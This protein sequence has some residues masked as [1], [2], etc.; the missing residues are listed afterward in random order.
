MTFT[1][2]PRRRFLQLIVVSAAGLGL[3]ACGGDD[4]D[5]DDRNDNGGE[6]IVVAPEF[7]PQSVCSG[8][9]RPDSVILWTRLY[10][11]ALA[12]SDATLRLQLALDEAFDEQVL[13][14]E[15]LPVRTAHDHCLKLKVVDLQPGTFYYY[16]FL[17]E[18]DGMLLST[19]TGRTRTA[20]APD[21]DV[22]VRF[23]VLNCQD[24]I[25]RY[26]NTLLHLLEQDPEPDFLVHVGDYIYETTG[27]PSFQGG[28]AGRTIAFSD[29]DGAIALG[30]GD[31]VFYAASSLGNYREIYQAYRADPVMQRLNERF[32]LIAIW[33]DHE[34]SDDCW[35]ATATFFDGLRDEADPARRLRA[36]QVYFEYMPVDYPTQPGTGV[37]EAD[38]SQLYPNT[39]LYRDLQ[40]GRHLHL[41]LTDYRSFR[42]DHLIPEDAFPGRILMDRAALVA[43]FEIQSPGNGEA[44][45]QQQAA[46]FNAYLDMG[47]E[48][49]SA[50]AQALVPLLAVIYVQAGLPEA[51]AGAKA[52]VDLG[53]LVAVVVLNSLIAQYNQLVDAGQLPGPALAPV[54]ADTEAGLDRGLSVALMGKSAFF[55]DFGSRY[56]VVKPSYELYRAYA[57]ATDL[58]SENAYGEVQ[59]GW[60]Q[61][62]IGNSSATFL[63]LASSV[64]STPLI[65]DF[66]G[67]A[68]FPP[69]F[70]TS[71]LINVD[72][73]D[74]FPNFRAA[75]LNLLRTRGNGFLFAGDIHAGFVTDHG[76]VA[77]FTA[78]A[79]SSGS[80][81][82]FVA[83]AAAGFEGLLGPDAF[84]R[85][86]ELVV[87]NLDATLQ[88][89]FPGIL[90]ART[91]MHGWPLI[92]VDGEK[93]TA[94][95]HLVDDEVVF[96]SY[97]DD[98]QA[99]AALIT[100]RRFEFTVGS[101]T[102]REI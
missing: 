59:L 101:N 62:R 9:P 95:Y 74:G 45:Y 68:S 54:D 18:M 72:H 13:E 17:F 102:L 15:G 98:P 11:P 32:P 57:S 67:E 41:L 87:E 97:Y 49:W 8:D 51:E 31:T 85:F 58:A 14:I 2:L 43:T 82:S 86:Q 35:Q 78:P 33:D 77:D 7:F 38:N 46:A 36:E 20:P 25:G 61:E 63:A 44:I 16:R 70:R 56:G 21:A 39:V 5:D 80:F 73:W 79:V 60:L 93:V 4:D 100:V 10:D 30:G 22:P 50:Y 71:F 94:E 40:F 23:A 52:Q 55:S 29:T 96:Q 92:T 53:G 48:P 26:Y 6:D 66:T 64:S 76:G 69:E 81:Q 75:L 28:N 84:Q 34:Y 91:A 90:M 99:L 24:Y 89:G 12:G 83:G 37:V 65:W 3:G 1:P 42:P 19:S 27:D 88:Q 47:T